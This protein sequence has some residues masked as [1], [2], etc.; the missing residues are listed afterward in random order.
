V[1][2]EFK[3]FIMKGD[4]IDLAVAFILAVAFS[5]V[6]ASLVGDV[7]TPLIAGII[8]KPD[9][10]AITIKVGDS[11]I[12]IGNFLNAVI[13]FVIVGF[14]LFMVVRAYNKMKKPNETAAEP[15]E[16]VKLLTQIR[17]ELAK[18]TRP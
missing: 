11:Q 10:G 1:L 3:A 13:N 8:G 16:E 15:S 6:V 14:V 17:D 2:K 5:T 18:S 7:F 4:L 12:L 9:F